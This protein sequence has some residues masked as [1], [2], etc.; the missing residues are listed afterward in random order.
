MRRPRNFRARNIQFRAA[1]TL[2]CLALSGCTIGSSNDDSDST[3]SN[4]IEPDNAATIDPADFLMQRESLTAWYEAQESDLDTNS[5]KKAGES[6]FRHYFSNQTISETVAH[7]GSHICFISGFAGP[8]R[9]PSQFR[10][11]MDARPW[12]RVIKTGI[13]PEAW[14]ECIPRT[15]FSGRRGFVPYQ[16][17]ATSA[18][19]GWTGAAFHNGQ[20]LVSISG[21]ANDFIKGSGFEDYIQVTQAASVASSNF[22]SSRTIN[23]VGFATPVIMMNSVTPSEG[24]RFNGP[25]GSGNA[26]TAGEY[27]VLAKNGE[28]KSL[29]LVS[30]ISNHCYFTS[31]GG[32]IATGQD[33]AQLAKTSPA[34]W[35]FL[36]VGSSPTGQVRVRVRC[37]PFTQL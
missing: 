18:G 6:I 29:A 22:V 15:N 4:N 33:Y 16:E 10:L 12:I 1:T 9:H 17:A 37:V 8:L 23:S 36:Y 13:G 14:V 2:T 7:H 28:L 5:V 11:G 31:V 34:G 19:P 30:G 20:T 26:T 25:F 24:I 27:H 35:Y 32:N 3:P 21:L